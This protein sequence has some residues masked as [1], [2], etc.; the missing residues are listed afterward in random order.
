VVANRI[1]L[2]SFAELADYRDRFRSED[3]QSAADDGCRDEQRIQAAI[4]RAEALASRHKFNEALRLLGS[5]VKQ[6]PNTPA[7]AS[8]YDTIARRAHAVK[9]LEVERALHDA[10]RLWRREPWRAARI[11]SALDLRSMPAVLAREVY[12]CWLAACRRL[13]L[14]GAVHYSTGTGRGAVLVPA[15]G[16]TRLI[17]VAAIG[18][19]SWSPGR[20]FAA[21][22]LRG[23]RPLA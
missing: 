10:R 6:N 4:E 14:A 23:A 19:R 2:R 21:T 9:T 22:A 17:V 16:D 13:G 7:S 18:L 12:G 8:S 1:V 20:C 15:K 5:T 11:L 3:N